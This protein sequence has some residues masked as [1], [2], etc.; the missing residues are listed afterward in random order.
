MSNIYIDTSS[1]IPFYF[2]EN[3]SNR[4]QKLFEKLGPF[5]ISELSKIEFISTARK[6][7]RM[8][9]ATESEVKKVYDVFNSHIE[10]GLFLKTDLNNHHFKSASSIIKTT[11]NSLRSLDALHLGIAYSEKYT[12]ISFDQ[13]FINTANEFNI[14]VIEE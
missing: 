4:V 2:K 5:H 6:K 7:V 12:V 13:I 10:Q 14:E 1:I 11:Q 8:R 9:D 3:Y